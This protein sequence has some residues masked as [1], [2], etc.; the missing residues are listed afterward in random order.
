LKQD[1]SLLTIKLDS[2]QKQCNEA[3]VL[4]EAKKHLNSAVMTIKV[5]RVSHSSTSDFALTKWGSPNAN[6]EKQRKRSLLNVNNKQ[7]NTIIICDKSV[8]ISSTA[9]SLKC[10][11][12]CMHRG[13]CLR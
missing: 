13:N 12:H 8:Y 3:D 11:K 2:L 4:A 9:Q 6:S 10:M 5:S 1:I 7:N